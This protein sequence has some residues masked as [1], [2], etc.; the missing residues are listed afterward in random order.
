MFILYYT[1]LHIPY[2]AVYFLYTVK[3][4]HCLIDIYIGSIV[5][6]TNDGLLHLS[7]FDTMET[8]N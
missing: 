7:K 6:R 5:F 1:R 2:L 4:S 8:R 3:K